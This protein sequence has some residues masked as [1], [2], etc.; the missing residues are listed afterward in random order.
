MVTHGRTGY[1]PQIDKPEGAAFSMPDK[2]RK[3]ASEIRWILFD[4]GGVLAEEGFHDALA[5]LSTR[6]GESA[7]I[8]PRLAM[9]AVYD[10]GYVTG[11]ADEEAFWGLLRQ[12]FPFTEADAEISGQILR[13]FTLRRPLLELV[14]ALRRNGYQTG[15]LSDQT[16]WLAKLDQRDHFFT[17]FDRI[18]NSY[19]L[20]K[21]KR[22]PTLFDEVIATLSIQPSQA[23]FIDDNP[24]NV[25]RAASRGL[26]AVHYEDTGRLIQR[27]SALLAI[28]AERLAGMAGD[29]RTLH[30]E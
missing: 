29:T 25:R 20:G 8:L 3:P 28:D 12:R 4:Y 26:C 30:V 6:Y 16:D 23:I 19:N 7:E 24:E 18:F 14:D 22:D 15:I 10:S 9:D 13:R 17:H 27:L 5:E 2:T 1:R 21:G 11:K